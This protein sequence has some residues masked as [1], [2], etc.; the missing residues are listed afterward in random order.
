MEG[1][2][3]EEWVRK[4]CEKGK[5]NLAMSEGRRGKFW[6]TFSELGLAQ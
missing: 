3:E 1:E 2:E 4:A 6:R 5:K